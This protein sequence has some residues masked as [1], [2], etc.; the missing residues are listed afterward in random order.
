MFSVHT[1][2]F[3]RLSVQ[4][5]RVGLMLVLWHQHDCIG[6]NEVWFFDTNVCQYRESCFS[7]NCISKQQCDS[8]FFAPFLFTSISVF[9]SMECV[10]VQFA[11]H[12]HWKFYFSLSVFFSVLLV[13]GFFPH[14][15]VPLLFDSFGFIQWKSVSFFFGYIQ[16]YTLHYTRYI[17]KCISH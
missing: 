13:T 10:C 11:F 4:T 15:F 9:L 17:K 8:V 12:Q 6:L 7:F 1:I 2:N 3:G 14:S 5:Y 16:P